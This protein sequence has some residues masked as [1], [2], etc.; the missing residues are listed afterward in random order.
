M[1]AKFTPGPWHYAKATKQIFTPDGELL[2]VSGV[3]QPCGYVDPEDECF[4]NSRLIAAAPDLLEA[5]VAVST[6]SNGG[7]TYCALCDFVSQAGHASDCKVGKAI[8]KA[9]A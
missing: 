1:N 9:T 4:G 8:L 3:A 2:R 5:L 7:F 6:K